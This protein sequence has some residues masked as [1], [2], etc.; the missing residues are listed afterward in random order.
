[1]AIKTL[2]CKLGS[3]NTY[4]SVDIANIALKYFTRVHGT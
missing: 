1:M 3:G 4:K 2:S